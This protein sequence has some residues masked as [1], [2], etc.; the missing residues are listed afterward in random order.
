MIII[1]NTRLIVGSANLDPRSDK[2][3]TEIVLFIKSQKLARKEK[4]ELH[5]FINLQNLYRLSW[6]IDPADK[7]RLEGPIW[8][9]MENEK[10]KRYYYPPDAAL[11]KRL[12]ADIISILPVKGYL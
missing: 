9:T 6:G 1:D 10:L 2:L 7:N 5:Q 4:E 12:G 11:W 8:E 3:N